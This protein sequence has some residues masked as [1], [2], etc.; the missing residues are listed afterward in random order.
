MQITRRTALAAGAALLAAP[1]VHAQGATTEISVQ[2]AMPAVFGP[3]QEEIAAAFMQ[4]NRDVRVTF[5]APAPNY[6]DGVQRVLREALANQAPDVAYVG[7][8]RIE[9]LAER[10]LAQDLA[11]FMGSAD[12]M[13]AAGFTPSLRS[14]GQA[15]GRQYGLGFA[16][17][18]PVIYANA[19]LIRRAGGNPDAFPS[20]WDGVIALGA[21]IKRAAPDSDGLYYHFFGSDWMWQAAIGS[22]GGRVL[23]NEGM[24]AFDD[25]RGLMAGRLL[26]RFHAEASHP[27]YNRNE[28][29]Q[30]FAAGRLGLMIDSSAFLANVQRSVGDRFPLA[31]RAFP[32]ASQADGWLPTGGAAAVM[33]A[34]DAA[35]Q[36]AAWRYMAFATGAD[37]A[38]RVVRGTGYLPTNQRAVDDPAFLGEFY[39]QNP[40]QAS[41]RSAVARLAPWYAFPGDRGVRA[42]SLIMRGL[43]DILDTG[44][45]PDA[46]VRRVAAEARRELGR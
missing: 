30:S 18:A 17:S 4:A 8:N 26:G 20:D 7:L 37:G 23:D 33:L 11:P 42:T 1:A 25:A 45:E 44:A 5:R 27:R 22:F 16:A 21:A 12:Q 41:V 29:Q 36:R 46:T 31:V 39:A 38:A 6:E 24:P 15:R 14:L 2:Y 10:Q 35:K 19:E 32:I 40:N 43:R 28:A 13:T 9:I 3:V 34:R